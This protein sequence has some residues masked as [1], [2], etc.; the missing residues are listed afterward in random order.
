[1]AHNHPDAVG[2]PARPLLT[3][4]RQRPEPQAESIDI[5]RG[6]KLE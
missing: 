6:V 4:S 3:L 1:V 5:G 2:A